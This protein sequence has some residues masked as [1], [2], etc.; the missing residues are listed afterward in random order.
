MTIDALAYPASG[1]S[2]GDFRLPSGSTLEI[3][4]MNPTDAGGT[5]A[6]SRLPQDAAEA[7]S[8]ADD[9][10]EV[11]YISPRA[12]LKSMWTLLVTAFTEPQS[13]TVIDVT[14]GEK[15]QSEAR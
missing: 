2:V 3:G 12:F 1:T 13:D 5:P 6:R 8:A 7:V 9:E 4:I 10:E 11:I 14:T 15:V